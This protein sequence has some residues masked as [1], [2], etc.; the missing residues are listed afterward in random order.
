[1]K[2]ATQHTR[3]NSVDAEAVMAALEENGFHATD[4]P[5]G[6][7]FY[8]RISLT[9][10]D[11]SS[12][13]P[14]PAAP[15]AGAGAGAAAASTTSGS[16]SSSSSASVTRTSR[17]VGLGPSGEA[18]WGEGFFLPLMRPAPLGTLLE[19]ELFAAKDDK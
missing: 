9:S 1:L 16:S 2:Q 14:A 19:V 4:A 6:A 12:T 5:G 15:A 3:D 17:V 10:P 11:S 8:A 13:A 7:Y 18:V